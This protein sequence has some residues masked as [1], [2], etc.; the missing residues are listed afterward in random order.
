MIIAWTVFTV[1]VVASFL[2]FGRTWLMDPKRWHIGWMSFAFTA[3][4]LI[5]AIEQQRGA[6]ACERW[7]WLQ[8]TLWIAMAGATLGL[9]RYWLADLAI[10][11]RWWRMQR[12]KR[13]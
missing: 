9:C 11:V 5:R 3:L 12:G 2:W 1:F 10:A 8:Y 13:R 6:M 4:V 7:D